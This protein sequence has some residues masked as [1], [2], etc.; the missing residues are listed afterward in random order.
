MAEQT[1][2][3]T[4]LGVSTDFILRGLNQYARTTKITVVG[5][6]IY[7]FKPDCRPFR[8]ILWFVD[9][10]LTGEWVMGSGIALTEQTIV[11]SEVAIDDSGELIFDYRQLTC[12]GR[13]VLL[14]P[15]QSPPML[16]QNER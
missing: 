6:V 11:I 7:N 12:E 2:T 16:R 13:E 15:L 9:Y 4:T 8:C 10:G 1:N 14:V 5:A 3:R